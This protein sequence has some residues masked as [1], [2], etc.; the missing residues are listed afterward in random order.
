MIVRSITPLLFSDRPR[1]GTG[2]RA[3]RPRRVCARAK[4]R[5]ARTDR[6]P[7]SALG[8][9]GGDPRAVLSTARENFLCNCLSGAK[10]IERPSRSA[11]ADRATKIEPE[12][13][14]HESQ[15]AIP[16]IAARS[17]AV[18]SQAK[19]MCGA[20]TDRGRESFGLPLGERRRG[21]SPEEFR[22]HRTSWARR[23]ARSYNRRGETRPTRLGPSRHGMRLAAC[24]FATSNS[25][26][27]EEAHAHTIPV[28]C[29]DSARNASRRCRATAAMAAAV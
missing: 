21:E 22:G 24:L 8:I 13:S 3:R 11:A 6:G 19:A 18:V 7:A 29:R 28:Y 15:I 12:A 20:S 2:G 14:C 4:R 16:A 27:H 26:S 25:V 1:I 5:T 23:V 10:L 17:L 9:R